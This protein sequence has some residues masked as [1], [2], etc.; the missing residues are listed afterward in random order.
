MEGISPEDIQQLRA[1]HESV[2]RHPQTVC[3]GGKS[4]TN[5]EIGEDGRDEDDEGFGSDEIEEEP[6]DP[7][8]ECWGCWLEVSEPVSDDREYHIN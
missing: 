6:H 4:K 8:Q 3:K 7:G 2:H 1:D 5:D